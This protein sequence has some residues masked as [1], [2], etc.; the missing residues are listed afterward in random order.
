MTEHDEGKQSNVHLNNTA[1]IW[2]VGGSAISLALFQL[3]GRQVAWLLLLGGAIILI[4]ALHQANPRR[5]EKL[6]LWLSQVD[7]RQGWALVGG[8]LILIGIAVRFGPRDIGLALSI[9]G[10][11][12]LA[13]GVW[14]LVRT[15][16]PMATPR[17]IIPAVTSD[18]AGEPSSE[19]DG[20]ARLSEEFRLRVSETVFRNA[21]TTSL[22][23]FII[24][25]TFF[26]VGIGLFILLAYGVFQLQK[27]TSPSSTEDQLGQFFAQ[28]LARR[29]NGVEGQ[30]LDAVLAQLSPLLLLILRDV[31]AR[32]LVP[33]VSLIIIALL[34]GRLVF[35]ATRLSQRRVIRETLAELGP[36]LD[37]LAG[38]PP[39]KPFMQVAEQSLRH[40]Q[41]AFNFRLWLSITL[42]IVGVFLLIVTAVRGLQP[43]ADDPITTATIAGSGVISFLV[44]LVTLRQKEI[45]ENLL[46][47]TQ[48]ETRVAQAAQ[49]SEIVDLYV[50]QMLRGAQPKQLKGVL[51][52]LDKL[53]TPVQG[54]T[55]MDS[56]RVSDADT[57][58]RER[59]NS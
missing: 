6:R 58:G 51:D 31:S 12:L 44:S 55:D 22:L 4:T 18:P 7:T 57:S 33:I 34:G 17:P 28:E 47:V 49:K 20:Y 30:S 46:Q 45:G 1:W 38:I 25:M 39:R 36:L 48:E 26:L 50:A 54:H 52:I 41:R 35:N 42:G 23:N 16:S 53:Q 14:F 40:T 37:T 5:W 43:G 29:M 24:G 13:G 11:L 10:V 59:P 32:Q 15:P 27:T 56:S 19:S 21:Q 9:V 2:L 3:L 8:I